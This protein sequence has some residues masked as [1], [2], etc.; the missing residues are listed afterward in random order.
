MRISFKK[1]LSNAFLL[2]LFWLAIGCDLDGSQKLSRDFPHKKSA[3]ESTMPR[4]IEETETIEDPATKKTKIKQKPKEGATLRD[5]KIM[6]KHFRQINATM[7]TLTTIPSS[8]PQIV[9]AYT[10]LESQLPD[11]NDA[12]SFLPAHQVAITKL[13]VEYCDAMI[14]SA[15][16]IALVLPNIELNRPASEALTTSNRE[17]IFKALIKRFWGNSLDSRPDE[18]LTLRTL[19]QLTDQLLANKDVNQPGLTA[20]TVKG[21][22]TAILASGPVILQ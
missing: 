14:N 15:S 21:I 13:S 2:P 5:E 10:K 22:C 18:G 19:H 11:T 20:G 4:P 6:I 8:N 12:R 3:N 16:A 7:S 1:Y 17:L 9:T